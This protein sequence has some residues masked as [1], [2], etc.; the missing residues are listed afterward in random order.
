MTIRD[1][2]EI[3]EETKLTKKVR[4]KQ[5]Q[6][7]AVKEPSTKAASIVGTGGQSDSFNGYTIVG[8]NDTQHNNRV[9]NTATGTGIESLPWPGCLCYAFLCERATRLVVL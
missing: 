9:N 6:E 3:A 4:R 5:I 1:I 2:R 7:P 8:D